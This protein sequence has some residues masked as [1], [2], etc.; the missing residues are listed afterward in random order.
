[1]DQS[2]DSNKIS[3]KII[4][5]FKKNKIKVYFLSFI[6]IALLLLLPFFAHQEN[7]KN[8]LIAEKFIKAGVLLSSKNE[9]KAKEIFEEIILSNNKFYSVLSLSTVLEKDLILNEKKILKY[10]SIVESSIKSKDQRDLLLL[11]KA[12]YLIKINKNSEGEQLLK[13]L[14]ND[15]SKF[16]SL[17]KEIISK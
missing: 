17:A 6:I 9:E 14:I 7:K 16:S 11:K 4:H 8:N 3:E 15:S 5:I 13:K 12:L 2:V 1:M 10:F